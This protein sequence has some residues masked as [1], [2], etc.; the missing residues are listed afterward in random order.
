[1]GKKYGLLTK[2]EVKIAGYWPR[3]FFA[4]LWTE[5]KASS[6]T[7]D[8]QTSSSPIPGIQIWR[9]D[10]VT[11][12]SSFIMTAKVEKCVHLATVSDTLVLST[13][14]PSLAHMLRTKKKE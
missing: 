3:S 8:L 12:V 7:Q 6:P 1:M 5:T 14:H 2:R 10:R 9:I 11:F 13:L 4:C